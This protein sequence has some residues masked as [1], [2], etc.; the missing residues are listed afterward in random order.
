MHMQKANI[1][2]RRRRP[3]R[4]GYKFTGWAL[5]ENGD[6]VTAINITADTTVY[7]Y[8]NLRISGILTRTVMTKV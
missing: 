2:F 6:T 7:A 1:R 3:A 4:A 8:G 5:S